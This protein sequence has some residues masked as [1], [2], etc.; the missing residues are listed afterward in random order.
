MYKC[1][2]CGT[3]YEIKPDY[4]DCGNDEF[5]VV[6]ES[7]PEPVPVAEPIPEKQE[8]IPVKIKPQPARSMKSVYKVPPAPKKSFD[9]QYPE[10]SRM[11]HSIEPISMTILLFCLALASYILFFAWNPDESQ[12]KTEEKTDTTVSK[13]IPSIDKF[14]NNA[15][16]VV[17]QQEVKQTKI[18]Q[19]EPKTIVQAPTPVVKT[20]TPVKTAATKTVSSQNKVT[21]TP[22]TKTTQQKTTKTTVNTQANAQK[23]AADAAA[24]KAQEEQAKKAAAEAAAKKAAQE[25]QAKKLAEEQAKKA[26]QEKAKQDAAAKQELAKYKI[27]LRNAIGHKIDFTKVIGD[28]DCIVAFKINSGGKL[29]SRSFA[30]QS[31]NMTLNDA[32]YAAVMATP[33]FNPPPSAYNNETLKLYIKFYNG[34]FEI[35]LQ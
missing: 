2:E 11:I 6:A 1:K 30:K 13:N 23:A 10:L 8:E 14:W 25:A 32:V 16:P 12:I 5:D 3:E 33:T 28:G 29:V 24:K 21:K 17:K 26:A 9:E 35:S 27:N 31:T 19:P 7:K 20:T 18:E 34:N 4:C 15:L 22:V